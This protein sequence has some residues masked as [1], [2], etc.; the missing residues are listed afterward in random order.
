MQQT[1]HRKE[2]RE[3]KELGSARD[4]SRSET[5]Q[6][7]SDGSNQDSKSSHSRGSKR[8][9]SSSKCGCELFVWQLCELCVCV[10]SHSHPAAHRP[11]QTCGICSFHSTD[12]L[13]LT[14]VRV[15]LFFYLHSVFPLFS[16]TPL[17]PILLFSVH[18]P[19]VVVFII[20]STCAVIPACYAL[21]FSTFSWRYQRK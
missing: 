6:R 16:P 2:S 12:Y 11:N 5:R 19:S 3:L 1:H 17:V 18:P 8:K 14:Y 21:L 13:T 10:A 15:F 20:T 7:G 9:R 4:H